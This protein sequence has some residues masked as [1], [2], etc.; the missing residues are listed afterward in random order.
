MPDSIRLYQRLRKRFRTVVNAVRT[1]YPSAS[2][3]Y[4]RGLPLRRMKRLLVGT[5]LFASVAG[6]GVNLNMLGRP[7][8]L[9][10]L[11]WPLLIGS[12]GTGILVVRLRKPRWI[13]F[14]L[15]LAII[16]GFAIGFAQLAHIPPRTPQRSWSL[17]DELLF[18]A[19][20]IW[21]G[22]GFGSRLIVSF[23]STEGAA[24]VRMQTE[25]GLA[26]EIQ[27]TL[28]PPISLDRP[29][30]ELYA[31]S[32]PS[33]E[34]GGDLVDAVE[35][36]GNLIAYVADVS[37]HGLPAGQLMGMLKTAMRLGIELRHKPVDLLRDADRVLPSLKQPDMYATL[38]LLRFDGSMEA[39]YSLAGQPPIL[40]YRKNSNDVAL[41]AMQ[42]FPVGLLLNPEYES[43]RA[44]FASGDLFLMLTDGIFEVTNEQNEEFGLEQVKRLVV[45]RAVEPLPNIW[46]SIR[47]AARAHGPQKD[48]QSGLLVR[49]R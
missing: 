6:F 34:M 46:E 43:A 26:H 1:A 22:V 21:I 13:F 42:Q 41:L 9:H 14:A 38:A 28:A 30:F 45:E 35:Q 12:V 25:L 32:L 27:T 16:A 3:P 20:G 47:S 8:L 29:R 44:P 5:F 49:V 48:D 39:E 2:N 19:I 33:A 23:L 17:R 11:F 10:D 36:D 7:P 15:P 37:G 18:N 24:S 31:I 40:H 4:W